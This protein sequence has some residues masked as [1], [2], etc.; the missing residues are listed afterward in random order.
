MIQLN[1]SSG[2]CLMLPSS[3][4]A[5]RGLDRVAGARAVD[6]DA[7]LPVR[8]ARLGEGGVDRRVVGDVA[9]AE[10][11]AEFGRDREALFFLQ[12]EDRDL[13][14]LG[15]ERARGGGAEARGTAGDDGGYGGIEFHDH[16]PFKPS[17]S[18]EGLGGACLGDA[19]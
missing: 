16:S 17:P 1:A 10:D 6:E 18:G 13:D 19:R 9:L 14:A 4:R 7:L 15:G 5:A 12:V 8:F 2:K 11:A 3:L